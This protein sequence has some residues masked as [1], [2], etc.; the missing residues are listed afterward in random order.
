MDS[1]N[2]LREKYSGGTHHPLRDHER[3]TE[4]LRDSALRAGDF[5]ASRV[6]HHRAAGPRSFE[7]RGTPI[8]AHDPASNPMATQVK[9]LGWDTWTLIFA[10][11]LLILSIVYVAY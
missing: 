8:A 7:L 5:S 6:R 11:V 9:T 4:T 1:G 3:S 2:V 10:L